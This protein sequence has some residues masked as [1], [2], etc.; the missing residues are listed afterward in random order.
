MNTKQNGGYP[1]QNNRNLGQIGETAAA[2]ILREKGYKIMCMNYRCKQGEIDIIAAKGIKLSF[3]E[4]KTRTTRSYGRPCE[5]V[6]STKQQRIRKAA[7]CYLNELERKG[8]VPAKVTFDVMEIV[9]EHIE[10][11]F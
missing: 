4:V 6:D 2:E 11:A 10:N 5:A 3:I 8:Y 1:H 9:A 7:H